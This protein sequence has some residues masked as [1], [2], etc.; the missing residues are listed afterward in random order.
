[1][2]EKGSPEQ[3]SLPKQIFGKINEKP[4]VN[5]SD[6]KFLKKWFE[7]NDSIVPKFVDTET[8]NPL[9]QSTDNK[10]ILIINKNLQFWEIKRL[11]G[12]INNDTFANS[13]DKNQ[14]VDKINKI[15]QT[16]EKAGIYLQ[17]YLP[18]D[19]KD[20]RKTAWIVSNEFYNYGLSLQSG[21]KTPRKIAL[22]IELSENEK[23]RLD[24]WF[25]GEKVWETRMERLG[26]NPTY[27]Q[28]EDKRKELISVYFNALS[29]ENFRDKTAKKIFKAIESPKKELIST[30]FDRGVEKLIT[31]K[32]DVKQD[33]I[34]VIDSLLEQKK[35]SLHAEQ[36]K[37]YETLEIPKL[38]IEL[39][40]FKKFGTIQDVA[41]KEKEI[42]LKI[43]M[44][45]SNLSYESHKNNPSEIVKNK[46]INCLGSSILGGGLLDKVGIKYLHATSSEHSVTLL[47]TSDHKIYWQDFTPPT[48][49]KSNQEI[50]N[51]SLADNLINL[52]N[53]S[54]NK[55][56]SLFI[57]KKN[58]EVLFNIFKPESD[59]PASV[60]N[61]VGNTL[62][63]LRRFKEASEF[64]KQSLDLNP[65]NPST[66][67]NFGN[68]LTKLG[69][70]EEAFKAYNQGLKINPEQTNIYQ[71]LGNIFY[72]TGRYQEA[73]KS[74]KKF[75]E[76][77]DSSN[78]KKIH[79]I[80]KAERI[81]SKLE[82]K[83]K[84]NLFKRIFN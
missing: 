55:N 78:D 6:Q 68:V 30:V 40:S 43:Q 51:P 18:N 22:N 50:K 14:R 19:N 2:S 62:K 45:I 3:S 65:N 32:K 76:L 77:S 46:F 20:S 15:G 53:S 56:L 31:E 33:N 9:R 41:Q 39:E 69:K 71:G 28:I 58:K 82:R 26:K 79:S 29:K 7:I 21:N 35:L 74:Y 83:N 67:S 75:I 60:L 11:V 36:K 23:I 12:V 59:L 47:L 81:I 63:N 27:K 70:Y 57:N 66:Y 80:K 24:K 13:E 64:Y 48:G 8:K 42:A 84:R 1:M 54:E 73:I 52:S 72:K 61:N 38:K 34:N 4:F 49:Y 5:P 17:Q 44:A 16:F 10:K 37:L 25:L